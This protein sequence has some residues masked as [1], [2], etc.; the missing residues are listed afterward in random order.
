MRELGEDKWSIIHAF[1]A[2]AGGVVLV[3]PDFPAFPIDAK[4]IH[5]LYS[6]GWLQ[7]PTITRGSIWDHS[8]TD[9]FAKVAA[10]IQSG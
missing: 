1:Y 3:T 9:V 5:Y 6:T 7:L 8:K 4:S 10:F 2:I